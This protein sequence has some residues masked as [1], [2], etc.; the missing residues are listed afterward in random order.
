M[1]FQVASGIRPLRSPSFEEPRQILGIIRTDSQSS[2]AQPKH[3]TIP[4]PQIPNPTA[5]QTHVDAPAIEQGGLANLNMLDVIV[6]DSSTKE[7][8]GAEAD[9]QVISFIGMYGPAGLSPEIVR[10]VNTAT[11]AA[12]KDPKVQKTIADRGDEPGG[13]TPEQ[14]GAMTRENYKLLG[15]VVKNNDIRAE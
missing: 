1:G 2:I 4:A 13:G 8:Q 12:L 3:H 7:R 15:D 9:R 14:L 6:P 11:N 5:T 10:K